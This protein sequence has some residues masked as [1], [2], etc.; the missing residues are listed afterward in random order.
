MRPMPWKST[1]TLC[2]LCEVVLRKL[3]GGIT[4]R[5]WDDRETVRGVEKDASYQDELAFACILVKQVKFKMRSLVWQSTWGGLASAET[6]Q[7]CTTP[8][9]R[10]LNLHD[11]TSRMSRYIIFA[12]VATPRHGTIPFRLNESSVSSY[13]ITEVMS[14]TSVE[15]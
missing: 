9:Q 11:S 6:R 1:H 10:C 14:R 15:K 2:K 4:W 3:I 5:C 13:S 7:W 12:M 8:R